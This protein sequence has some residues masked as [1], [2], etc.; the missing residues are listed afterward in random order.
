MTTKSPKTER[1]VTFDCRAF[2]STPEPGSFIVSAG[3]RRVSKIIE[4]TKVRHVGQGARRSQEYRL[5][6]T[7]A[8]RTDIGTDDKLIRI[9][10]D[11]RPTKG[12]TAAQPT[13]PDQGATRA[14][15]A[16]RDRAEQVAIEAMRVSELLRDDR[17]KHR[18]V[19]SIRTKTIIDPTSK[20]IIRNP[21]A[22]S[23]SWRD[24]DDIAPN[25]RVARQIQGYRA[26]DTLSRMSKRSS[27][28][29]SKHKAAANRLRTDSE[30][31]AG[32]RPGYQRP[33]ISDRSF[34]SGSGPQE[35]QLIALRSFESA[36]A[37]VGRKLF[38]ILDHVVLQ[39][40][41]LEEFARIHHIQKDFAMGRFISALDRLSE[42]YDPPKQRH[43]IRT[44]TR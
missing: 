22:E 44:D 34:G 26:T 20:A 9:K 37:A 25:R 17:D 7:P 30:L 3:G 23:A 5:R 14:A 1:T 43:T 40:R 32:A 12:H 16:K 6:V 39:N 21:T 8:A 4:A 36:K 15:R 35:M 28:I 19:H 18:Q 10:R 42:H 2:T 13:D 33:E 24:P 38:D 11:W 31:A 41:F 29:T 27:H